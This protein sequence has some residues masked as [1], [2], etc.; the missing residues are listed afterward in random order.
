[1]EVYD[2][3]TATYFKFLL[4]FIENTKNKLQFCYFRDMNF[5]V[6]KKREVFDNKLS[7]LAIF[8]TNFAEKTSANLK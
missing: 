4:P 3:G 8:G 1:M 7:R 6:S 5:R 2:F